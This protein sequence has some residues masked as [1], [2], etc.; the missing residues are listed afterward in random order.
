VGAGR[1]GEDGESSGLSSPPT[2]DIEVE[3]Q[4]VEPPLKK[5]RRDPASRGPGE[6]GRVLRPRT[7]RL[8]K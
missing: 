2:S 4:P 3:E 1:S 6:P 5:V 8:K 7:S